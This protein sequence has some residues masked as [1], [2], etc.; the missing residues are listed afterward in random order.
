MAVAWIVPD[1]GVEA[2]VS[3]TIRS[4]INDLLPD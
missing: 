4:D 2:F 1:S 3:I